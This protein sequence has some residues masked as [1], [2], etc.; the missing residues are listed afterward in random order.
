MAEEEGQ[1][2]SAADAWLELAVPTEPEAVDAVTE[3]LGTWGEGVAIEHPVHSSLD[4]DVVEIPTDVPVVVKT[5]LPL[6]DPRF[7][8]RREKIE[9]GVWAL[10]QIRQVGPLAVR[11]LHEQEW[12]EAWKTYF[13]VHRIGQRLVIVPSW[14]EQEYE[15]RPGDVPLLLDPGMAFGTGLHPSTRLCLRALETEPPSGHV[16]D[17]G[18]GSGILSIA[19]AKLGADHVEAVE[20][21]PVAANVCAENVARNGVADRVHVTAGTLDALPPDARFDLALANITIR[22]ILEVRQALAAHLKPGARAV[23][24]GVLAERADELVVALAADGWQHERTDQE[25]DWVGVVA[26]AP[27]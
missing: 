22:V 4:G 2:H 1:A 7:E 23:F 15:P 16:L 18:A 5:F 3:L 26:R 20:I 27:S 24:S 19:A 10:G 14:R 8:E 9:R 25:G 21:E 6:L 12:A 17:L 11:A 13:F